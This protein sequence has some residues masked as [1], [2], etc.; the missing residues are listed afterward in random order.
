MLHRIDA[1][2]PGFDSRLPWLQLIDIALLEIG[3]RKPH[4]GNLPATLHRQAFEPLRGFL[5]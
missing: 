1:G 3:L 5:L 2:E 4:L